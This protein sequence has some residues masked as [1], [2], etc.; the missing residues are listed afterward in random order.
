MTP[1][2][3]ELAGRAVEGSNSLSTVAPRVSEALTDLRF[4]EPVYVTRPTMPSF[5][6]YCDSLRDIWDSR[7]LT[8]QGKYHRRL[9]EQ[10]SRYLGEEHLSLFCNG[11]L[12]LLVALQMLRIDGG[13]V[14]TTPFTF[15]ATAHVLHWNRVAP[16]FADID[17]VTL[18]IDPARVEEQIGPETRA[19]LAVHVYGRACDTAAIET[20]ADRHGLKVIYD[21]AHAF[22]VRQGGRSLT[23]SG[24]ISM[25]SFHATKVFTCMEGG[26]LVCRSRKDKER[27]D[28][29]KNFGIADEESVI[30]PGINGKMHEGSAAFGLLHLETVEAEIERR[31]E[32]A[33]RYSERLAGTPG[34]TLVCGTEDPETRP[35]HSYYPILLSPDEF[36]MTRDD[37]NAVLRSL[38]VISRKYFHPLASAYPCYSDLPSSDPERL[39]VATRVAREVLCLPIYGDLGLEAVDRIADI[40]LAAREHARG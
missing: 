30:G 25:L 22:G 8:N 26:A 23:A 15:P 11:T 18:N 10:L 19:I 38:N 40:I 36:G 33:R 12:A 21:A 1:L 2:P 7:W 17:P 24:D 13:E 5:D 37:L 35:N 4:D 29:L 20:L 14:I 3:V 27:V 9:E 28:H 34:L 31:G 39:P 32:L 16:V 6:A